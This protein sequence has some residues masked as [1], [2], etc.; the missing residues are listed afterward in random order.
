MRAIVYAE[1]GPS[2]VMRLAERPVPEPGPGQVLVRLVRAGVNPTDWK[3]RASSTRSA[4][5]CQAWRP[6]TRYG[7]TCPGSLA[8]QLVLVQ[9][10]AGAVGNAAIR[11]LAQDGEG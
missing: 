8:G 4:R 2:S 6:A 1:K 9:G 5:A 3:A 7:C 11:R 10:G